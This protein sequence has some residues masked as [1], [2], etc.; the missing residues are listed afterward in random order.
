MLL[1][2]MLDIIIKDNIADKELEIL[3]KELGRN[4]FARYLPIFNLFPTSFQ[5]QYYAYKERMYAQHQAEAKHYDM[6]DVHNDIFSSSRKKTR[7]FLKNTYDSSIDPAELIDNLNHYVD[8]IRSLIENHYNALKK[9]LTFIKGHMTEYSPQAKED[10]VYALKYF[11]DREDPEEKKVVLSPLIESM[12]TYGGGSDTF[13]YSCM[14]GLTERLLDSVN[15][16]MDS[17]QKQD[18]VFNDAYREYASSILHAFDGKEGRKL[19][20]SGLWYVLGGLDVEWE[21]KEGVIHQLMYNGKSIKDLDVSEREEALR[22]L[23]LFF[24]VWSRFFKE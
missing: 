3:T 9:Y 1:Q 17:H 12:T 2:E 20:L 15:A 7:N 23:R 4:S 18:L 11:M 13:S 16:V 6:K 21:K 24:K 8:S 14:P 19:L 10:F 22:S 5:K